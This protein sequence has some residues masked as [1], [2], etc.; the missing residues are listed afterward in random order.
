M[1]YDEA[2]RTYADRHGVRASPQLTVTDDEVAEMLE[3]RI[4]DMTVIDVGGGIG[5]LG[6]HMAEVAKRVIVIEANPVWAAAWIDLLHRR[7]P[8]N[9]PFF[10]GSANQLSDLITADVAVITTHSDVSGMMSVASTIATIAIDFYG[11]LIDGN[12]AAFDPWAREARKK[13]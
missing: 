12:P 13:A 5:L 6:L 11:E 1:H 7:K 4:R 3:P 8:E 2:A 10:F 9:L